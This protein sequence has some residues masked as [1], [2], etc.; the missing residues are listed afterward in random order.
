LTVSGFPVKLD[1]FQAVQKRRPKNLRKRGAYFCWPNFA[2]LHFQ[3]Y[4]KKA[5]LPSAPY[6]DSKFF[7]TYHKPIRTRFSRAER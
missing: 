6:K 2:V 7:F 3:L 5:T 4:G 1:K